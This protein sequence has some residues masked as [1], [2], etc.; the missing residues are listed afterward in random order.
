M[1]IKE[2]R[3][4][5]NGFCYVWIMNEEGELLEHSEVRKLSNLYDD[6]TVVKIS[7]DFGTVFDDTHYNHFNVLIDQNKIEDFVIGLNIYIV[8]QPSE[9]SI[10]SPNCEKTT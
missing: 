5:I 10:I 3:S 4:V 7:P 2:L 1:T 6:S 9:N 8:E